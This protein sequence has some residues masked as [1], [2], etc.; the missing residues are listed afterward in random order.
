MLFNREPVLILGVVRAAVVL[1]TA[2]GLDLNAEQVAGI[3]LGAEAVLS[4]LTRQKVTPVDR[5]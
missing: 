2:F 4:L 5:P 1:V 3:Y